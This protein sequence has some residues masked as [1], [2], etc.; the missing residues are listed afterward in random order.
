MLFLSSFTY[1]SLQADRQA[2]EQVTR[3]E[4]MTKAAF[5][6]DPILHYIYTMLHTKL[7]LHTYDD[8]DYIFHPNMLKGLSQYDL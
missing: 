2:G 6:T 1:S 8:V 5:G 3:E 7:Q 4:I